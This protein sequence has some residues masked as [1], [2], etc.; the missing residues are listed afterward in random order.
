MIGILLFNVAINN[1]SFY[2]F[3]IM[4]ASFIV[5]TSSPGGVMLSV[6]ASSVVD[7]RFKTRSC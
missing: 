3:L 4:A 5:G 6:L 2:M 1:I 7:C